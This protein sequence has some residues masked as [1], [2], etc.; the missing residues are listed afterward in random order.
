K[1]DQRTFDAVQSARERSQGDLHNFSRNS[2][3]ASWPAGSRKTSGA[4]R[5]AG[6]RDRRRKRAVA[7]L[8]KYHSGFTYSQPDPE[9]VAFCKC[10][11]VFFTNSLAERVCCAVADVCISRRQPSSDRVG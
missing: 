7:S 3:Q 1:T 5:S 9:S 8:G 6:E 10:D 11:T 2:R 4:L